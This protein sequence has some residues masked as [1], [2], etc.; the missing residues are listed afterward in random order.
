MR[1]QRF[2]S[3]AVALSVFCFGSLPA[4]LEGQSCAGASDYVET[5]LKAYRSQGSNLIAGR[6]NCEDGLLWLSVSNT[7]YELNCGV[8]RQTYVVIRDAWRE[9]GGSNVILQDLVGTVVAEFRVLSS[10]P[11]ILDCD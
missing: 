1:Q 11:K 5:V 3:L 8:R 7:W 10:R 4:E 6:Y 9:R 2:G